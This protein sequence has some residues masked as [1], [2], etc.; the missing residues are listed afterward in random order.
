MRRMPAAW[1]TAF[2]LAALGL[3]YMTAV[4]TAD[5][6]SRP[7]RTFVT[8]GPVHA[9]AAT[10]SAIYIGGFFDT[11]GPRTGPGAGIDRP[12]G[13]TLALPPVAGGDELVSVAVPDGSG[14]FFIGGD[15]SR[16]GSASR[17][18]L[19]HILA[20]GRVDPNFDPRPDEYVR[21]ILVSGSTVYV[22][23]SFHQIGGETRL[24]AAAL[25]AANG[26]PTAWNPEPRGP[27]YALANS[28]DTLYLGG[29]FDSVAGVKRH[30]LAAVD[31]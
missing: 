17:R 28:G 26:E 24:N 27:V 18:N 23:G 4:A 31:A 19:A 29:R 16:V 1:A 3:L 25:D 12:T 10:K 20:D 21:A 9:I 7:G 22:G 14:G 5:L 2:L 6:R 11:V 13:R 30:R 15:F 8:D